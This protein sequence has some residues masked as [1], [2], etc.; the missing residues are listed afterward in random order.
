MY[1][2]ESHAISIKIRSRRMR[3]VGDAA[4]MQQIKVLPE[5]LKRRRFGRF[6]HRWEH[7]IEIN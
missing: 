6:R 5:K 7:N 2:I 4:H 3:W 1:T